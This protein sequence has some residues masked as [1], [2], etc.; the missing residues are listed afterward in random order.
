MHHDAHSGTLPDTTE[1]MAVDPCETE[2]TN[3]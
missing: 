1:R 3:S 2:I